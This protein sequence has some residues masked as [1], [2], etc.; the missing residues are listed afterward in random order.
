[1]SVFRR[2]SGRRRPMSKFA[3]GVIGIV[4]LTLF[5]YGG[6]TKFANPFASHFTVYFISPSSNSLRPNSLVRIAGVN[7][8]K[9]TTITTD[10]GYAKIAID[11]QNNGLP[12]HT[13]ATF[14]I[15][16]R[17][18]LEGN[19][20]VDV[21]PGTPSAPT[22]SSG[23][24]FPIQQ[25]R[26]P[27]QID[28]VLNTLQADTRKNLQILLKEYGTGVYVGGDAFNRSIPYWLPAYK[29]TAIVQHDLLGLQPHDLSN[30]IY[31]QGTVSGAFN[32]H[33]QALQSLIT[34]FNTTALAFARE[35]GALQNTVAQLPP[36]LAA[37][38]PAFNALNAAFPPVRALARA[39]LP[40]VNSTGPAIDASLPFINQL[41]LLVQP[42]ELQGLTQDLVPTVPALANLTNQTIPL[43]R[44]Q[45]RPASSCVV[46]N[47]IPWSNLQI[48]DSNFNAS[49][50]FPPHPAY[51]EDLQLLPG[52]AGESRTFDANGP[53]IRLLFGGGA[54]TY[55]IQPGS[56]GSLLSP[57]L[58]VQPVAPPN[59]ERPPLAGGDVPN[60]PCETQPPLTN[61]NAP[62]GP[63]PTQIHLAVTPASSAL[64]QTSAKL[65]SQ[66]LKAKDGVLKPAGGSAPSS[67]PGSTAR[68][69]SGAASAKSK[70][71]SSRR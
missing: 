62:E 1:M 32:S 45:V 10:P 14:W 70:V 16:P 38:T 22:I 25:A 42:S 58:G 57:L 28:Q 26:L 36:T 24:V 69:S 71:E 39:L 27:V 2:K 41:R 37:A 61:L 49:N 13:D 29:S 6:F 50:G 53:V 56:F 63:P 5:V 17:I 68:A 64:Q 43:M 60:A 18:F 20:F 55:S 21:S 47:V 7:V 11:M 3:A 52:I 23:H 9:V 15:R 54:F 65:L 51:I 31:A 44:D 33:P 19:F 35:S 46:Q 40:G 48:N 8:G 67:N 12:L 59:N 66:V 4:V 34:D 30:A